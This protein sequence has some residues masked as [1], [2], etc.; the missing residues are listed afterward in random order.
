[1]IGFT[2]TLY[3]PLGITGNYSANTDL[4]TLHLTVTH[5]H[6]GVLILH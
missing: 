1:M 5:T 2:D 6:S 4:H 3:T